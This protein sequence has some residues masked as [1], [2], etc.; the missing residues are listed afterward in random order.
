MIVGAPAIAG[1]A[2][3]ASSDHTLFRLDRATGV[4]RWKVD[5]DD[6]PEAQINASPVVVDGL[7]LQG[8]ASFE[9]ILNKPV[10]TFRGSIAAYDARTGAQRWK[11]STT[12]GDATAGPG[13]GVW[14]TPAVDRHRGLLFVGTGQSLAEPTAPLAD[15]LLAIHYKTGKL[16]WSR[17][18]SYPDVFSAGHPNGKDAD[19]GASPNLWRANGRD[20]VGAGDKGGTF[21]AVDRDTG[22]LVWE[23]RLAPGGFFGGEIGSA[24]LVDGSLIASSN[25][26]DPDQSAPSDVAKV[27]ALDPR[28]G[29][30]RWTAPEVP[31]RIFAPVSAV[32]GVAFVGTDQGLLLAL[33]VATGRR[34]WSFEAPDKTACGPSI[35]NGRLIWGYGFT[36]FQG[37]GAGGVLSF[38][39]GA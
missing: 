13:V 2:I 26:S 9:N 27:F 19:V 6:H 21:H 36:L 18:F 11:F 17:Q 22:K 24:A 15:S 20:L 34:L 8:T 4:Q 29:R 1:N 16:A 31:G 14:S 25:D 10:Y 5:V 39:V 37:A 30:I 33:S 28:N 23:T 12:P 32:R 7:V 38:T 3:Y 35:V